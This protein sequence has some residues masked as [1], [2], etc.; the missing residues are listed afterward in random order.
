ML[1]QALHGTLTAALFWCELLTETLL[2]N[3]FKLNPYDFCVA[4]IKINGKQCTILYNVDDAK[5]SHSEYETVTKVYDML[6]NHFGPMK[7]KRGKEHEFIGM[8]IKHRDDGRFNLGMKPCLEA[9]I[10]E[11]GEEPIC[12]ATPARSDL[13]MVDDT[14][15]LVDE[16]RKKLFHR[17]VYRTIFCT[18]RGRKDLE[19]TVSFYL[20]VQIFVTKMIVAN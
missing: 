8:K 1:N 19:P 11:F 15:P 20:N 12:A 6:V 5:V 14:K 4:N 18:G 10:E 17:L 2:K 16:H 9:T 13:F 7:I 3:G